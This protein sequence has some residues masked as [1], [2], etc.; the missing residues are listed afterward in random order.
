M[1]A[2]LSARVVF[3]LALS[4]FFFIVFNAPVSFFMG[5]PDYSGA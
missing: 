4:V 1:I 2:W 5:L 3:V